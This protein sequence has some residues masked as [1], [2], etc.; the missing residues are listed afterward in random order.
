MT[1]R[2]LTLGSFIVL[3]GASAGPAQAPP[4]PAPPPINPAQAKLDQTLA[5]LDGPGLGL[6]L[7]EGPGI[8]AA[9]CEGGTIQYWDRDVLLGVRMGDRTPNV[10]RGHQGS[11]TALAWQGGPLLASAGTDQKILLWSMPGGKIA[12]GLA[13]PSLVRALA[14][15]PDGKLLAGSLDDYTLQIWD[16]ATGKPGPKLAGH[17]DWVLALA[18]SPDGKTLASGGYDGTVR[19]WEAAS[20]KKLLDVPIKTPAKPNEPPPAPNTVLALAFSPDGKQLAAGGTDTLIY[21]VQ[22][23]DGKVVRTMTGCTGSVTG[24]D[25]HPG[26]AVLASACK[27]R[28]V[29]LWNPTNGQLIKALEGHTAWVQGVTFLA[30][31]TR[32]ASVGADQ[33]VRLWDLGAGKK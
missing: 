17:T 27:D 12:N 8:L 18:F 21:L 5:G 22:T 15:S 25:F 26:G 1:S 7:G 32:L 11:I 14:L 33:T 3:A 29:R 30:Q 16:T 20:G 6:A 23:A 13:V 31:G 28:V 19:L 10:L 24:L 4:S 2:L 9:A